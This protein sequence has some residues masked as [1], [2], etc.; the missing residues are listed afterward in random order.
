MNDSVTKNRLREEQI[1]EIAKK[2][3]GKG[4]GIY[5][6]TELE[7]GFCNAAYR[8]ELL[9]GRECVLKVA[10]GKD[11]VMMSCEQGMMRTEV[12]AMQLARQNGISGVPEVYF[13]EEY[14]AVSGGAFFLMECLQGVSSAVA[15]QRMTE[16]EK[17]RADREIGGYLRE[18]NR[19]KGEKFG[20]FWMRELQWGDWFT[21][22][23]HLLNNVTEDGKRVGIEIGVPYDAIMDKLGQHRA[24]FG[25]VTE[26]SFIHFDSW[27]GNIFMKD[28]HLV[29]MIDWE[30]AMWAEGLM[31][32]RFRY[33]T[34]SEAFLEGYGL[35]G[36]TKAQRVRCAWYDVY[37]YLIMMFEGTYRHYKTND[38]YTWVHGLFEKVW[39]SLEEEESIWN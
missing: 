24:Y 9:D 14:S 1:L 5:K 30:R 27:D 2:A 29:G 21:A 13:F 4:T 28:G 23:Y 33:H 17:K 26:P 19:I 3:F 39:K 11:V 35:N 15:K 38:Q 18:L 20:H 6:C 16:E 7:D 34:R 25:E 37:L 36:M 12:E 8:I 31:E 32:D 10:P 22:F